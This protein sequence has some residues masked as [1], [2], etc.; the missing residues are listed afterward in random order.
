VRFDFQHNLGEEHALQ[1]FDMNKIVDYSIAIIFY[2]LIIL[3]S[4]CIVILPI[5][6]TSDDYYNFHFPDHPSS[7]NTVTYLVISVALFSVAYVGL[8]TILKKR[9]NFF[10]SGNYGWPKFIKYSFDIQFAIAILLAISLFS[11]GTNSNF[12]LSVLIIITLF[13]PWGIRKL[14]KLAE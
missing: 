1:L 6:K 12:G 4:L 2:L 5:V 10:Q 3:A 8:Y 14:F 13:L 11:K 9:R 7:N